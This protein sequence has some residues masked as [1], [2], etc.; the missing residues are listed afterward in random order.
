MDWM[1]PGVLHK[2]EL[3]SIV[4]QDGSGLGPLDFVQNTHRFSL[5]QHTT[6]FLH[7]RGGY[8]ATK[9]QFYV[10]INSTIAHVSSSIFVGVL[11]RRGIG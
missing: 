5:I 2:Y 1:K 11:D 4:V 7:T 9:D 6:T 10:P 8:T 3:T